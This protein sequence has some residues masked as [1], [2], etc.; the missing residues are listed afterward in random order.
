MTTKRLPRQKG[1]LVNWTKDSIGL[2]Q[3]I[4]LYV[5]RVFDKY[6]FGF[7]YDATIS[8]LSDQSLGALEISASYKFN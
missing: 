5:R 8:K 6:S 7:S 2:Q 1:G 3:S 4:E